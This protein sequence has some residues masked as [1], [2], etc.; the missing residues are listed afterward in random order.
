MGTE[1]S[2]PNQEKKKMPHTLTE[3]ININLRNQLSFNPKGPKRM[4]LA[5]TKITP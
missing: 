2:A 4:R 3:E 1:N 5:N